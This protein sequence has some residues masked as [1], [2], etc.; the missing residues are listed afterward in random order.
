MLLWFCETS[1][2]YKLRVRASIKTM[3]IV[4]LPKEDRECTKEPNAI[5]IVRFEFQMLS[6]LSYKV[7]HGRISVFSQWRISASKMFGFLNFL[8]K[9]N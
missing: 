6:N 5:L 3:S 4:T 1:G 9:A 8:I 2:I 7:E